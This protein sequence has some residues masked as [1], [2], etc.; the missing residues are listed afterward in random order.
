[1]ADST[2]TIANNTPAIYLMLKAK[3]FQVVL[4]TLPHNLNPPQ[5]QH[6]TKGDKGESSQP[7][8]NNSGTDL[9]YTFHYVDQ[10]WQR[11]KCQELQMKFNRVKR[12]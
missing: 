2:S 6:H 4:S 1:M 10:Q 11:E 12:S 3:H 8:N 7:H 9:Q 5:Q